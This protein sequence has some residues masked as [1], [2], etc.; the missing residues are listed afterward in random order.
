VSRMNGQTRKKM[1]QYLCKRD[2][3]YCRGCGVKSPKS[4]LVIDHKDNNNSNNQV[5]NFQLLCRRCNYKK[6][7]RRP[8]DVCVRESATQAISELEESRKKEPKFRKYIAHEINENEV[9]L[10]EELINS[11]AEVIGISPVTAKRYMNKI[12]SKA[13]IYQRFETPK[14]TYVEFKPELEFA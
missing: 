1:Y 4:Q 8:V 12:C 6:N 14:G 10:E 3:E 7:P 5:D 11:G 9:A 2:G 13:G